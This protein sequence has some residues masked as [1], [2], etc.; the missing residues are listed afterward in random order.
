MSGEWSSMMGPACV[1]RNAR[2]GSRWGH[3][4]T[5]SAPASI[6]GWVLSMSCRARPQRVARCTKA[7]PAHL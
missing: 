6:S 4:R 7:Y 2:A 1:A 5:P 3:A